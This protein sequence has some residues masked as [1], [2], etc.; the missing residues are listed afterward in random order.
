MLVV[1][2]K[3]V[4]S[5]VVPVT[6]RGFSAMETPSLLKLSLSLPPRRNVRQAFAVRDRDYLY[7]NTDITGFTLTGGGRALQ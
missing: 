1:Y 5:V 2:D 4:V 7:R 3:S 6:I